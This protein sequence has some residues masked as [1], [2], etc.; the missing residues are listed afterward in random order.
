MDFSSARDNSFSMV[1]QEL[2]RIARRA[3]KGWGFE[4]LRSHDLAHEIYLRLHDSGAFKSDQHFRRVAA[5]VARH[6]LVDHARAKAADKRG[7]HL[8]RVSFH[9][10]RVGTPPLSP[11]DILDLDEALVELEKVSEGQAEL[12]QMLYFGKMTPSEVTEALGIIDR[13]FRRWHLAARAWLHR[14]FVKRGQQPPRTD[15]PRVHDPPPDPA[16]PTE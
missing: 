1:Y 13:R 2:V 11:E 8:A 5:R 3:R 12:I 6:I 9:E 4:S 15:P 10:S 14:W 7:G 16:N